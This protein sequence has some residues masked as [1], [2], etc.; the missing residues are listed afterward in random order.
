MV[1]L[2]LAKIVVPVVSPIAIVLLVDAL[3]GAL[4]GVP[5]LGGNAHHSLEALGNAAL[6]RGV[7]SLAWT[8]I[9]RSVGTR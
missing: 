9:A 7:P 3:A 1:L 2:A 8:A 6:R 4:H 5:S